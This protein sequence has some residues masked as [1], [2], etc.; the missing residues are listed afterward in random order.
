MIAAHGT[1]CNGMCRTSISSHIVSVKV[2]R[3]MSHLHEGNACACSQQW[4]QVR[5][6]NQPKARHGHAM[7]TI[8]QQ[9]FMCGGECVTGKSFTCNP[10]C[11]RRARLQPFSLSTV[12]NI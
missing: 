11:F 3:K 1:Y 12:F 10:D 8:G 9:I 6:S 7:A 5:L 2:F 4:V